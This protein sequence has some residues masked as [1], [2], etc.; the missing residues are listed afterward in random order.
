MSSTVRHLGSRRWGVTATATDAVFT[1]TGGSP[2]VAA[3][4]APRIWPGRAVALASRDVP[5]VIARI[6][7]VMTTPRYWAARYRHQA[8]GRPG[9][10]GSAEDWSPVWEVDGFACLTGP[11]G[12]WDPGTAHLGFRPADRFAVALPDVRG[13]LI[14]LSAHLAALGQPSPGNPAHG[15]GGYVGRHRADHL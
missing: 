14:R 7:Q 10:R 15:G 3:A 1:V 4:V 11:V 5:V 13:L 6:A 2:A 12:T 8:H 9:R